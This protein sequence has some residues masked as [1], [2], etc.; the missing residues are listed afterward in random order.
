[1]ISKIKRKQKTVNR[2]TINSK[3]KIRKYI[4]GSDKA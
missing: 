2:I 1:M 3:N 4:K